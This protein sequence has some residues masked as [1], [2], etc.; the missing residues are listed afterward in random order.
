MPASL[1]PPPP[2]DAGTG[3]RSRAPAWGDHP[4]EMR[5]VRRSF[6][7]VVA[8]SGISLAVAGGTILGIIGPSGSGKTTTIRVITGSLAPDQ[9][10]VRVLGEDPRRFRRAT[11]ERIGYMPQLFVLYPDLTTR[12]NVDFMAAT[13]GLLWRRRRR[14]VREV[15]QLVDLW[16]A[17]D[18]RAS[19]LSGGMQRRLELACALVHEPSLLV[20]D[21]P[22][23]GIDPVLRR[24]VWDEL[25]RLRDAG[26]TILVTTQYVTEAEYCD[27]VALISEGDLVAYAPPD[28][29]R[30]E[31]LGGEVIEVV[32]KRP[33]DARVLP[34][35]DG[36]AEIR[37]IGPRELLVI[38]GDAA[39]ANP[40]VV[41]AID[42]AGGDVE[43][44]SEYR[45]S[46]DEVFTALVTRHA[47]QK[48]NGG[49][50]GQPTAAVP[51][52]LRRPR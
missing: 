10:T 44:S 13:F 42:A 22:T 49:G 17:R 35:I 11:R 18:R 34:A 16:D 1:P 2:P 19:Q 28:E 26:V 29:V 20:L 32:T 23:A 3:E 45:P 50:G 33:F 5:D 14:R 6:G 39:H 24:R 36:I 12:E 15:L 8:V 37:Q 52:P 9:G 38:T 25:G 31:A 48:A 51:A 46:F 30:R 43:T 40:A 21:E 4:V 7:P 27:T 47:E 41:D